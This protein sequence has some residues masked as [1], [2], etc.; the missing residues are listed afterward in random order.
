VNSA[1]ARK[2]EP[3][4]VDRWGRLL[5]GLSILALTALGIFH[6]PAWLIGTLLSSGSLVLT[7]LTGR[8]AIHD[9]L[10][11]LGAKEREDIFLPGGLVRPEAAP[12]LKDSCFWNEP[13][14][15]QPST[16]SRR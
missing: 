8:C 12:K 10:M 13:G 14:A 2:P 11:R 6:H 5:S 15:H 9:L 7:A 3:W 16:A 1:N 4:S